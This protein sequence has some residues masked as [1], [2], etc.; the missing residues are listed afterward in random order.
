MGPGQRQK[1]LEINLNSAIYG[2]FAEIGAGQEVARH[3]FQAGGA[4]GT[5]AKSIS[6]YDMTMS[7]VIYG[8]EDSGRYVCEDRLHKMLNREF[9]QL[10]ERLGSVRPKETTFFAFADTVAAKSFKGTNDCH[11]WMGVRFQHRPGAKA[12]EAIIHVRMLDAENVQQ[13]EALGMIGVNLMYAVYQYADDREQ[14][15]ASLMDGLTSAR[16]QI[17]MIRVKGPAFKDADSRLFCLELIKKH[18]CDAVIFDS[19]GETVQPSDVLYK[20]NVL[21]VRGG[22]RPPTLLSLDM[23]ES[24][25]RKFK[26]TLPAN[27]H[28]N[29][30]VMPE[31]SVSLLLERG[32]VDHEDFLARVDLLAAL[33]HKVLI[34]NFE[35]FAVL[36]QHLSK[37]SRKSLA[38]VLGV[39]NLEDILNVHNYQDHKNG[40]MTTIGLLTE[41]GTKL[42]IYPASDEKTKEMKRLENL[43]IPDEVT[44]LVL[45]LTENGTIQDIEDYNPEVIHIWSRTVLRMIQNGE[46][47][48]EKMVPKSVAKA[49]KSHCLFGAKCDL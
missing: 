19:N 29:I 40:L 47:G 48:W 10:I 33:G 25:L 12:S 16:M 32:Q 7:D 18:F 27:E 28:E 36:N 23:L 45:H 21:V 20:K 41:P 30:L 1:A 43:S 15:V 17:D 9:D 5:I 35:N 44:F 24:G 4:A 37:L 8:K 42:F 31:I 6:A 46:E 14:F 2:T 11:G 39:Y 22:Y 34:S 3:F 49:V 13:Q 26:S 38:F